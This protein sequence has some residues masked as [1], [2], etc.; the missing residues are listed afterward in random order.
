M[1]SP[2]KH[3]IRGID[4]KYRCLKAGKPRP[5][6]ITVNNSDEKSQ[7]KCCNS[8]D[9]KPWNWIKKN[10]EKTH[11][12]FSILTPKTRRMGNKHWLWAEHTWKL[13]YTKEEEE[14]SNRVLHNG[15][16]DFRNIT[17]LP[18]EKLVVGKFLHNVYRGIIY[19]IDIKRWN[20]S[21]K[22]VKICLNFTL[23]QKRCRAWYVRC[24]ACLQNTQK[25]VCKVS[26]FREQIFQRKN[27]IT[28]SL[29][30]FSPTID[31]KNE[32]SQLWYEKLVVFH[33]TKL[34][35]LQKFRMNGNYEC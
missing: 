9:V 26:P 32:T 18:T 29:I 14:C 11:W 4:G 20:Y 3:K 17:Y 12:V 24:R 33:W 21:R 1:L 7:F 30:F 10:S 34:M 35:M 22:E 19:M 28:W 16:E 31:A 2:N 23:N 27:T 6:K 5:K 25:R 15:V 8:T 13:R